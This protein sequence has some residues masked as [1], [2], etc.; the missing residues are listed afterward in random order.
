VDG[1]RLFIMTG[2][3]PIA[4]VRTTLDDLLACAQ[5]ASGAAAVEVPDEGEVG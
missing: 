1:S 4:S 5:A 3:A 2:P